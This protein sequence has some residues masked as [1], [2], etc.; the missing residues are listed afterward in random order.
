MSVSQLDLIQ[1]AMERESKTNILFLD[2]CRDSPLSR[3]LARALGT[4]SIGIGRGLALVW[5]SSNPVKAR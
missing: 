1:R 4:R 5:P 2:A 3:N